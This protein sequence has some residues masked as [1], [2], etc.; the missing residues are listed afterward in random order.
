MVDSSEDHREAAIACT[1]TTLVV[2]P[3][4]AVGHADLPPN[5]VA[6]FPANFE[7]PTGHYD[8][9]QVTKE[10]IQIIVSFVMFVMLGTICAK[11]F[12]A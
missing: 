1:H 10:N 12:L 2:K 6:D 5:L 4:E 3:P 11:G 7:I 9:F 8:E